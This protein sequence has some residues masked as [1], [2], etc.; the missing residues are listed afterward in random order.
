MSKRRVSAEEVVKCEEQYEKG[1]T[2]DSIIV[3]VARKRDVS[4]ESLYEKIAW[5]L[6]R[7]YGHSYEAFKLSITWVPFS[8]LC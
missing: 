2:V 5:P 3:Q 8:P 6:H 7:Q 1:K 4:P